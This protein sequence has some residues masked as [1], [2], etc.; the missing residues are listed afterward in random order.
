MRRILA[1]IVDR[2]LSASDGDG[3]PVPDGEHAQIDPLVL[4][5]LLIQG[6]QGPGGD[7]TKSGTDDLPAPQNLFKR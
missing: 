6:I 7:V 5:Q 1:K 4:V 2:S 3:Q